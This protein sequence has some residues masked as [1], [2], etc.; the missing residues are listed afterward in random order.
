M[1]ARAIAHLAKRLSDA[2]AAGLIAMARL[3]QVLLS[4]W[5]GRQCRFVPTCSQYFIEAVSRHG[6][7]RGLVMGVWRILRCNPLCKGG[8]GPVRPAPAER[9]AGPS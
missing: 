9:R 4:P 7:L 3:Y 2:L 5:L 6:P 8:Y 1:I